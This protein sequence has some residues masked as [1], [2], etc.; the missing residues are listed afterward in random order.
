MG[1]AVKGTKRSAPKNATSAPA[2]KAKVVAKPVSPESEE[3]E[4]EED[5]EDEEVDMAE[6]ESSE[7]ELDELD[8]DE[9][10]V[11]ADDDSDSSSDDLESSDDE[12]KEAN[13][14]D[15]EKEDSDKPVDPNKK[16]SKEQHAEQRKV[17]AERKLQRKSGTEVQ[18]IKNL[19]EKL[20]VKKPTPPKQVRDKLCD[21]IWNLSKDVIYDLVLKHDASRVVQTLVKFSPKER[22]DVIV[23][24]LKGSY[25]QLATSSY[26]KYLLVKLL[27]YG[28]KESRALIVDELHGKLRKLMRHREGAYVVE[29]LFVLY[30]TTEQRQQMIREFWGAEYAVFRDSGKGKSV[31]DVVHESAEKKQ[32]IMANLSGTI[33]ASVEKGST[34]FQILHAAMKDYTTILLEDT[35]AHDKQLREFIEL[36]TEQFAELVHTQEGSEVACKLIAV[37]SAKERK[38]IVRHLKTHATNL[39][40]NENGNLVLITIFM[41]VDDTVMLHKSFS[42]DLFTDDLLPPLIQD[43]FSRRPLL[44]LLNGL[45]GKYFAPNVKAALQ[46]Y[47]ALAYQKTSKKPQEQRRLELLSRALP[48][49]YGTLIASSKPDFK[50]PDLAFDKLMFVNIAAQ[51]ITELILTP[52]PEDSEKEVSELRPQL[53]DAIFDIS[54]KGDVLE[55]HHLINKVPFV[56]RSLKALIQGN[57]FKWDNAEKKLV[58]VEGEDV[59]IPG[60][61]VEFAARVVDEIL[62]N[63]SLEAWLSGQGAFV[64]VA[65]YEVLQLSQ[66][67]KFKDLS[68]ALKKMKKTLSGDKD[69]KGAQL[70]LKLM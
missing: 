68:K 47:E 39:I 26:G 18:Q 67:A 2:K 19:W 40:K 52:S 29:D 31:L 35:E 11:N 55:D 6:E 50:Y 49:V 28:S 17:L 65:V 34:G 37:A 33:T 58:R 38:L 5:S 3:S 46:S 48:L 32:L 36:L 4:E 21:E 45:D 51:V 53:V 30:S 42:V 44:Y 60:V 20:R 16:T 64:I 13:S 12:D 14:D 15:E 10:K 43:K 24:S 61:G 54:V 1:S 63:N 23:S 56:S 66:D 8:D 25:Y 69:N 9:T 57:E 22:R 70:L 27:H 7:D 62:E 59:K 41:T